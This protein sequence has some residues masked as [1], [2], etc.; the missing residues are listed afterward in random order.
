MLDSIYLLFVFE[1]LPKNLGSFFIEKKVVMYAKMRIFVLLLIDKKRMKK[2][3]LE[4]ALKKLGCSFFRHGGNHDTWSYENGRKFPFARH[5]DINERTA[6]SMI[7]K[8]SE[9]RGK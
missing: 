1:K 9:N 2:L 3:K 4:K 5:P 7:K 8:A 6:K